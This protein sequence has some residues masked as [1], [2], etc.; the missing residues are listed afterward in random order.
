MQ[1]G[2]PGLRLQP[3]DEVRRSVASEAAF[4]RST[5]AKAVVVG[6]TLTAY[7]SSRVAGIPLVASH[8][9]SF[10]PPV[11][12][13][14]LMPVPS[15]MSIPGTEW[16]PAPLKRLMANR[17][18]DRMTWPTAFLNDVAA[19]LGVV[20]ARVDHGRDQQRHRRARAR[21]CRHP[22]R[23]RELR[24]Y[25][26]RAAQHHAGHRHEHRAHVVDRRGDEIDVAGLGA[27]GEQLV[28]AVGL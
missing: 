3:P 23:W 22:G 9:G 25:H 2:R 19:E 18:T 26:L 10:V 16:L 5:G 20:E 1:I 14:G 4:L 24:Q 7:L 28:V 13:L 8:G 11:A 21:E 17:S 6:F 12:E 15:Q 27:V